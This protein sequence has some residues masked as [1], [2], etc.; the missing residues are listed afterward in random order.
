KL[1]IRNSK[2]RPRKKTSRP[3]RSV[4]HFRRRHGRRLNFSFFLLFTSN[5][6]SKL[7]GRPRRSVPL[8]R[9]HGRRQNY[10]N[11]ATAAA[12]LATRTTPWTMPAK[13]PLFAT[14][15]AFRPARGVIGTSLRPSRFSANHSFVFLNSFSF[16]HGYRRF[17][18]F[19]QF[20]I[21][22]SGLRGRFRHV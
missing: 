2:L 14:R 8:R 17:L 11:R 19:R 21:L 12:W 6:L 15:H 13:N 10:V 7:A 9:R 3:R 16:V 1:E 4:P 20:P 22:S 5:H 18:P